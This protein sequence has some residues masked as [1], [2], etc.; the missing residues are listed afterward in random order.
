V[1]ALSAL[2]VVLAIIAVVVLVTSGGSGG[3]TAYSPAV[4][5]RFTAGCEV[6]APAS[7]SPSTVSGFCTA[8]LSCVEQHIS[9]GQLAVVGEAVADGG[10]DPYAAQ[11]AA[12][13]T[14]AVASTPGTGGLRTTL[15]SPQ[16]GDD[17]AKELARTAETTVDTIGTDNNGSYVEVNGKPS[18]VSSYENTIPTAPGNDSAY[19]S[20]VTGTANSYSVTTTSTSGNT[21]TVNDLNGIITR[22]CTPP[23][24]THGGCFNG[25]W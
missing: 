6:H 1:Q 17:S 20:A 2:G 14:S 10:T 3:G 7:W 15:S 21:F 19:L 25:T 5:Q 13:A 4:A 11:V 24:G 12:C 22:T 8:A 16:T 23:H 18:V 9:Q